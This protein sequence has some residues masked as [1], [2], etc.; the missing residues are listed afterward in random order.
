[1]KVF[2]ESIKPSTIALILS[3]TI[4]TAAYFTHMADYQ[5]IAYPIGLAF[6]GVHLI[7]RSIESYRENK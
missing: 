1:M 7:C 5:L 3:A 4:A 6:I 2:L